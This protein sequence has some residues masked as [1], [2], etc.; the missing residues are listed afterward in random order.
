MQTAIQATPPK[1]VHTIPATINLQEEV[2]NAHKQLRV[3]AYCR[4]STK[5]EDQLNSYDV[6]RRAYT[7]KI[8]GEPGWTMVGIY[9]DKG[10][11]GTSVK[12]RDD[13]N[14][15]MRHCKQGK[16][17][18]II[19]KSVARFARNTLDC[20]KHIEALANHP[21]SYDD[22][23]VRQILESVI[24]ESKEKIKVVFVGGLEVT[25]TI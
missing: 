21:I 16:V 1:V 23:I 24:V 4:V 12:K 25:Q 20:L 8:N 9:A 6:Q 18:M 19:T 17:D 5:Q 14:R 15:L 11:T 3:A 2:K 10:I 13:F 7:D 22:Q